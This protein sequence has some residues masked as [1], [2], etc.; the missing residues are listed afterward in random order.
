MEFEIF[1]NLSKTLYICKRHGEKL[2]KGLLPTI[3]M[4][5]FN[6]R[7]NEV[8]TRD[9]TLKRFSDTFI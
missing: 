8:A 1:N 9:V 5:L 2:K 7:R 4:E 3:A 6:N